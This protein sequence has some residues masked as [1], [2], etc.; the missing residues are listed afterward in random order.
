MA[1][2]LHIERLGSNI[3]LDEW[4]TAASAMDS[5]RPRATG[6]TAVNPNTGERIEIDQSNGDL[7]IA[8]PQSRLAR[9]LGKAKEWEPAFFFSQGRA[10]FHPPDN[11]ASASNPMCMVASQLAKALNA[12]IIGDEGEEY[13]W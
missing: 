13:V 5:L 10:S 8:L 4:I 9:V 11:I 2:S 3:T 12:R 1:Y 7:E 6:Y